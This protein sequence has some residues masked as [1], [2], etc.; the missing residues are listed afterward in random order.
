MAKNEAPKTAITPTRNEDYPEW[1]QQVVRAADLA[2]SSPVRGCMVIKPWGYAI[3]ENIQRE[4][5]SM[6][7]ATGHKNAYFPLFIPKSFLEKEAEHVEGFAK[8]CAVVTHHRLVAGPG[9]GLIPDP[10]ARLE[11]PLIVRPTSETIIGAAFASWVQSYRDLPLLINQWANVVR[12]EL[13]TRLFLRTAE[14]LWQ[15]GHT[16]HATEAEAREETLRMLGV[17]ATFARDFIGMPVLEGPKTAS[18][19]FPGAVDTYAIEAMMQDRKALQA[20]TSHFLGQNFA[21]AS[22]IKFQTKQETEEYAWTTSWGVTTRLV[23][24]LIMTHSDDD[25]LVL[26]PRLAPAHVVILPVYRGDDTRAK[27]DEYIDGLANELRAQRFG[28][29]RVEVEIDRRDIR[30]G[31]KQ[32]E[33]VKKGV[34]LRIEIGPR[35]VDGGVAMVMRR[36]RSPKDKASMAR[37]ELTGRITEILA[38]IQAT[39]Y[40][41]ALAMRDAN[42]HVIDSRADFD[43]FFGSKGGKEAPGGFALA[44]WSGD[45]EVEAAVKDA[46]KVTIRCIPTGGFE[47]A[48]W[49]DAVTGEGTCIFTGKPSPR[50]VVFARSY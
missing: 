24:A 21:R 44:H 25:G 46:H 29:R 22:G 45:P 15:E 23:G 11:E 48:P 7:K 30:G 50:R 17:Y 27:I 18:E 4:L 20:G 2:E 34:P 43:A 5:D 3:W 8:E 10:Q 32:W 14:F 19:R 38:D 39:L 12:W 37:A 26:P 13:R 49:A 35:D 16:A 28:E 33:W 36:D 9:G 6:I 41:R 31:E 40:A 47:G 42:T 1:Y